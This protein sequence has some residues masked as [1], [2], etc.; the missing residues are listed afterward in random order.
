MERNNGNVEKIQYRVRRGGVGGGGTEKYY[1]CFSL[2]VRIFCL[3]DHRSRR[4]CQA[5]QVLLRVAFHG[6]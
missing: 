6:L 3:F 2:K 4:K 1:Y 5:F